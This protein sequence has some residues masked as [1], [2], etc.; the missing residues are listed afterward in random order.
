MFRLLYTAIFRL[1]LK[2]R[3][4]DIQLEMFYVCLT[5]HLVYNCITNQHDALFVSTLLRY[6]ASTCFRIIFSP[7]SG[8]RVYNVAN[9]TCLS[10]EST[11]CCYLCSTTCFH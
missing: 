3:F 10:S 7:S 5:V 6:H 9:G 2:R 1:Q 8:G 4:F 11:V